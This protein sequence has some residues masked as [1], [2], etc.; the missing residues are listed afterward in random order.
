MRYENGAAECCDKHKIPVV[1]IGAGGTGIQIAESIFAGND[2]LFVGFL[3]DGAEKQEQGYRSLPVLGGLKTW[4]DL[5][6][7]YL[8]IN[9]LYGP[10]NNSFF[11]ELIHSL[12]IPESRWATVIDPRAIISTS[13]TF[14]YGV[15]V[16]A[17]TVVC[18]YVHLSNLCCVLSNSNVSHDTRLDEYVY[19]ANSV[20]MSGG[21][22]V[23]SVSYIG[24][25]CSIKEY[26]KIGSHAVVGMGSVVI[27][28]VE[29]G[30]IVAGNPAH[31]ICR[32]ESNA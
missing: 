31:V 26:I 17:G 16:G 28:N 20:S 24:A 13:A 3:D 9:S 6:D 10:K 19:C 12:G 7:D 29:D 22:S 4:S 14:G 8:F 18:A 25:N 2:K 21:I 32:Q 23:G 5:P 15:Y 30:C 1:V 27:R 11:C